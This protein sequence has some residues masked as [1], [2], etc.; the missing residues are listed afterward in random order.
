M[1]KL[2]DALNLDEDTLKQIK[3]ELITKIKDSNLNAYIIDEV[4]L[5]IN[6]S[7]IPILIKDNINVKGW[8][9]TAGSA[10]LQGYKSPYNA[11]AIN[12]LIKNNLAPFGRANMDEFA[13]GS[14]TESSFYGA[15]LNPR[16]TSRVPGGSSGGSAAAVAGGIALAAL[17]SDTGGSIRQP[18]GYCG[19]VGLKPTYGSVSRYG[20]IAYSSSL[21]QI[22]PITQDVR[23]SA[24]LFDFI[25]GFDKLDS[26]SRNIDLGETFKSLNPKRKFRVGILKD[27]LKEANS[28]IADAYFA[29][30]QKLE[31]LGHSIKEISMLDTNYH[32]SAYYITSMAEA[33]SNLARFDGIRYGN[34][35][36]NPKNLKDLYIQT[37]TK[38]FRE[39][40]KRRIL[41]GNFVLSSGYYDAYYLKAQRVRDFIAFQYSEMFKNVDII[42]SPIAPNIAPKIGENLS[43][44]EM[45]LSDIYTIGVNLAGLPGICIPV[46]QS[47][48]NLPIGMQF[49]GNHFREQDVLDIALNVESNI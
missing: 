4:S 28:E 18:A 35:A 30:S 5:D 40:V 45:Y 17:G 14:T 32:I 6:K 24:L 29:L 43:P 42:L 15:T 37:R 27:S 3:T 19:C 48:E 21:D 26:T 47:R 46:A 13:M 39:E 2:R 16:D 49:I 38:G 34:R 12:N 41:I 44:L 11:T 20:L 1:I 22:G 9:I 7:G 31:N 36:E 10:I 33:S 23:D 25:K 8:E